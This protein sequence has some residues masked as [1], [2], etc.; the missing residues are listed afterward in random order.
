MQKEFKT[1]INEYLKNN[2]KRRHK[3]Q[4]LTVISVAIIF[5]VYSVLTKPAIS[6]AYD[7]I[8]VEAMRENTSFG[9]V[10]PVRITAEA[11]QGTEPTTFV[12]YTKG[13]GGGLTSEYHFE[14]GSCQITA[15]DGSMIEL[16]KEDIVD[17]ESGN[18]VKHNYWFTLQPEE[19]TEFV[20]HYTSD[21]EVITTDSDSDATEATTEK[22]VEEEK[23]ETTTEKAAEE[24]KTEA[25]TEKAAE[26]EKTEATT[27]KA[28][29]EEKTEA[30]TEKAAEEEKTEATTEKA[31]EEEKTEAT[32]EKAKEEEKTEPTTE[33]A[34]EEEKA[35]DVTQK[36]DQQEKKVEETIEKQDEVKDEEV[37]VRANKVG[38]DAT[39]EEEGKVSTENT[40]VTMV[41]PTTFNKIA[42]A[43]VEYIVADNDADHEESADTEQTSTESQEATTIE[44]DGS[45]EATTEVDTTSDSTETVT[46][47]NTSS[48]V[49]ETTIDQYLEIYVAASTDGT[50]E[51]IA[52]QLEEKVD[53]WQGNVPA[54]QITTH[55][56]ASLSWTDEENITDIILKARTENGTLVTVSGNKNNFN[57]SDLKNISIKA[58]ES[59]D[60][61]MET[62]KS[63]LENDERSILERKGFQILFLSNGQEIQP[64]GEFNI[65]FDN[66]EYNKD[67]EV[68]EV[69]QMSEEEIL[70]KVDSTF[71]EDGNLHII[72]NGTSYKRNEIVFLGNVTTTKV[73]KDGLTA[74]HITKEWEDGKEPEDISEIGVHI[75]NN[76]GEE[77]ATTTLTKQSGWRA[78]VKDLP[79]Y[80][81][82][83][84]LIQ[85]SVVEDEIEGY[86]SGIAEYSGQ[87]KVWVPVEE[88]EI[89]EDSEYLTI[90][91]ENDKQYVYSSQDPSNKVEITGTQ[92]GEQVIK[93][94]NDTETSCLI[95]EE[96]E[97]AE[98][99]GIELKTDVELESNI[100]HV[101][102]IEAAVN[103]EEE[104][105]ISTY[106]P[107]SLKTSIEGEETNKDTSSIES[108]KEEYTDSVILLTSGSNESNGSTTVT[109][110]KEWIDGESH[111]DSVTVQL[112][113]RYKGENSWKESHKLSGYILV[114][115]EANNW[116]GQWTNL[117]IQNGSKQY[118]YT[119]REVEVP[120]GYEAITATNQEY[121]G[122]AV[123][124]LENNQTYLVL[125][126]NGYTFNSRLGVVRI[127]SIG[128]EEAN[129]SSNQWIVETSSDGI[130]LKNAYNGQYIDLKT[131]KNY[132]WRLVENKSS[133]VKF[134]YS[135]NMLYAKYN[136]KNY[137]IQLSDEGM[138]TTTKSSDA[139]KFTFYKIYSTTE[140]TI[141]NKKYTNQLD[142][143]DGIFPHTK[144]IDYLG[145]GG[146]DSNEYTEVTDSDAY[147][148]YLDLASNA[149]PEPVDVVLVI[150]QSNSMSETWSNKV[151]KAT[152]VNQEAKE[153]VNKILTNSGDNRISVIGYAEAA[154]TQMTWSSNLGDVEDAIDRA[155]DP[156]Y[157]GTNIM[158]AL[159][160][161]KNLL[162]NNT[163]SRKKYVFFLTD[164][165]P[166]FYYSTTN[167]E[168]DEWSQGNYFD[169]GYSPKLEGDGTENSLADSN[170]PTI[171]Y[172]KKVREELKGVTFYS[173]GVDIGGDSTYAD[174][175]LDA[176]ASSSDLHLTAEK[177]NSEQLTK[178][179]ETLLRGLEADQLSITDTL[180]QYVDLNQNADIVVTMQERTDISG[181]CN[182]SNKEMIILWKGSW[183]GTKIVS[184]DVNTNVVSDHMIQ[185]HEDRN[186]KGTSIMKEITYDPKTKQ[187]KAIFNPDYKINGDY[188]YTL[189]FNIV[190]TEEAKEEF[191]D[192]EYPM[193]SSDEMMKGDLETDYGLNTTSSN[194]IGLFANKFN[195]STYQQEEGNVNISYHV[196]GKKE[197]TTEVYQE[198]PVVQVPEKDA[199][200]LVLTK[201]DVTNTNITLEG[202]QFDL[203]REDEM[204]KNTIKI[205]GKE[206]KVVKLNTNSLVTDENGQID[207][208]T[209]IGQSNLIDGTY[210]LVETKAYT[211]YKISGP[212]SFVLSS[213]NVIIDSSNTML[214]ATKEGESY[215]LT[216]KNT[217][218]A[219]LPETGGMG[220]TIFIMIGV[221]TMTMAVVGIIYTRKRQEYRG[222]R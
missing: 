181:N 18:V 111:P 46:E 1:K 130:Y 85:Y 164:G 49:M 221:T 59:S 203:Y 177:G 64:T 115:S 209:I 205:D 2:T 211:E 131:E 107:L 22:T 91:K 144:K 137:Y 77:V 8:S 44:D 55:K 40:D 192:Q 143:T 139:T 200:N 189:S 9:Q 78:T 212:Y 7:N 47:S 149:L 156:K 108:Y 29:E 157:E 213:G 170:Q 165:A 175:V 58:E 16:H 168:E 56:V 141:Q 182:D 136:R 33:K 67:T 117:P 199:Y 183:D 110:T 6:M 207:L 69:Y 154:E 57:E 126:S 160:E 128:S 5:L 66:L 24:E 34:T 26:E 21:V 73:S 113:Q 80:N 28:A 127:S 48:D 15:E 135:N 163:T 38:T 176:I 87:E 222:E 116:T 10:V 134:T 214:V 72:A 132:S 13:V 186:S 30:T 103:G 174:P 217:K 105:T 53:G 114:L 17:K 102:E 19:K 142:D 158:D 151:T 96:E 50:Y 76:I 94:I 180:S 150:D 99:L 95:I 121:N 68:V 106:N 104:L 37:K 88:E 138:S 65:T 210:Y 74:I 93:E 83:G 41:N 167:S 171:T 178:A 25:T 220:T 31:A 148:L 86:P 197:V 14:N 179:F 70:Q 190:V 97:I 118:E 194:K 32:T 206:V 45:T 188:V 145:D 155:T 123:T 120:D 42:M 43:E 84:E 89:T 122:E 195:E 119:V 71:S 173:L 4:V 75:Y 191:A 162:N 193:I 61:D 153:L 219:S 129:D 109:V 3:Y 11:L 146:N 54:E 90:I 198:R 169:E 216:V 62:L 218:T 124:T 23:T 185:I 161:T 52:A 159:R 12:I 63:M 215:G 98:Q 140:V 100:E 204:S 196:I 20:L 184:E 60:I 166:T 187:I 82:D 202:V 147:R 81:E 112:Y 27:E 79:L 39:I 36:V 201:V 208:T 133:A 35:E 152:K 172:A 51:E 125:S 101:D 92:L